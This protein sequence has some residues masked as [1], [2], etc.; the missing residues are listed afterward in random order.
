MF[1][2]K[3]SVLCMLAL[4]VAPLGAWAQKTTTKVPAISSLSPTNTS[5]SG[6]GGALTV[7]G[8]NFTSGSVVRWNGSSRTTT[9][10]SATQ[11]KGTITATDLATAGTAQVTV[12]TSGK[13]GGTSS[14]LTFTINAGTTTTTTSVLAISTTSVPGGTATSSYG[15]TLAATGGTSPYAWGTSGGSLPPGLS[16]SSAGALSGTPSTAGTY[17]FSVM[18]TDHANGTATQNYSLT[19]GSAPSGGPSPI[20]ITPTSLPAG[21]PGTAYSQTLTATGGTAPYSWSTGTS[22]TLPSGFMLASTGALSGTPT[23]G[24]YSFSIQATDSASNTATQN[25]TLTIA[26]P[27]GGPAALPQLT[28]DTTFPDTTNYAVTQVAAGGDLQSAINNASCSP[29]GTVLRLASGA[30]FTGNYTLPAKSCASGKWIIVR[31]DTADG[32]LPGP[33]VRINPTYSSVLA[34]IMSNNSSGAL[35]TAA[36]ASYYWFMGLEI[37][38]TSTV[39]SG[40]AAFAV[41][42]RAETSTSQLPNNIIVDRCYIH[43]NPTGAL[44]RGIEV[45]GI[46]VAVINSWISDFHDTGADTQAVWGYNTPGPI[47]IQ[48]NELEAAGENVLFGGKDPNIPNLVVSDI[49]ITN[50]HFFKPLTWWS[51]SPSYAGILWSVKNH[52]ELKNAQRVLV[53]GNIFEYDWAQSQGGTSILF[54]PRNQDG[55]CPWCTVADVTFCYNIIRHANGG[56]G[57]GG[58]DHEAGPS[59]PSQRI[60]IHDNLI[61]DINDA[62]YAPGAGYAMLY[63]IGAT[64]NGAPHDIVIDHNTG[65]ASRRTAI[66]PDEITPQPISNSFRFT[67]NIGVYGLYGFS[68]PLGDGTRGLNAYFSNWTFTNNV[69]QGLQAQGVS[70]L[71]YPVGNNFPADWKTV[72]FVDSTNCPAPPASGAAVDQDLSICALSSSSPYVSQGT[73]GQNI[74]ANI[75]AIVAATAGV[76]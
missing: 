25:Y 50:N 69:I 38:F 12:F 3:L 44:R 42:G 33:G 57:I 46:S 35:W 74:G 68:G 5:A 31:T 9:Y 1:K 34:K 40:Y 70:P 62:V 64:S 15:Q 18:V 54:T 24:T 13:G 7:N 2:T 47:L 10:V 76:K 65:I 20:T 45:D 32:S 4:L 16:L 19:V 27:A 8:S 59:E 6:A 36:S 48:N 53:Q 66:L 72:S 21:T 71:T 75:G 58:A 30:T 55:T 28:I 73:D 51:N 41:G 56:F 61:Y 23:A 14:A 17:P 22:G 43:G 63:A 11:L 60:Y 29:N 49:T 67:N 26:V 39:S 37:G 52:F